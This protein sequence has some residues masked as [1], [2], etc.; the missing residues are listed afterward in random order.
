VQDGVAHLT[1]NR[2]ERSN[3]WSPAMEVEYFGLLRRAQADHDVRA[4]VVSGSGRSFCPGMDTQ[5][6]SNSSN[7]SRDQAPEFREPQTFPATVLKPVIIAIHGA[8]AGTGLIQACMG[9]VRFAEADAR[10]TAA[11]PRRGIMAEHGLSVLLPALV[12]RAHALD[13]LLSGRV[14]SGRETAAMGLTSLSEPGHALEDALAYAR[15]LAA[16]CSPLAMAITKK[17]LYSR[18]SSELE[19]ARLEAIGIWKSLREHGDFKEGV[20]SFLERRPPEFAP[21][22]DAEVAEVELIWNGMESRL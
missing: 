3:A 17:Q 14:L 11:F 6:L 20:Q 15:D 18:I 16:N 10:I 19:H 21:L 4:I 13:I 1:L 5:L 22:G 7:G 12:G 2:P 9:D 8:C